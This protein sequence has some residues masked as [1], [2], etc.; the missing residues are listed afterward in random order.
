VTQRIAIV[1]A[2]ISGLTAAYLL[3]RRHEVVVYEALDRLGGHSRTVVVDDPHGPQ[4]V[5]TGFIVYN[6]RTY[7]NFCRCSSSGRR[8]PGQRHELQLPDEGAAW[9][10]APRSRGASSPSRRNLVS[11]LSGACCARSCASTAR[12]RACWPPPTR[13]LCCRVPG[14]TGYSPSSSRHLYPVR[15]HLVEPPRRHGGVSRR[16]LVRFFLNHGLLSLTDRPAL[17]HHRR[18]LAPLR[19]EADRPLPRP[20]PHGPP[21]T[22]VRARADGVTVTR[23]QRARTSSTRPSSPATPTRRSP[24]WPTPT[25][26]GGR[27]VLEAFPYAQ[28]RRCC[29]PTP[30]S[31]RAARR[32]GEL[33]L[34][35]ACRRRPRRVVVTYDQNRLQ[36]LRSRRP[37]W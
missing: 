21:V 24:C 4:A 14:R 25:S 31:C 29:T 8:H 1:G 18:R 28:A 22:R 33:E 6:R 9:S 16:R 32:L 5:D 17:A 34:P 35:P 36:N 26:A 15:R 11:P 13:D 3:S 30:R 19:R 27:E 7:P 12:P 20:H 2:G 23:R 10:T 37:T